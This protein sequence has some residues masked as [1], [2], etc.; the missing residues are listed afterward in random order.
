MK[1]YDDHDD[2]IQRDID[3]RITE[4]ER[5]R[6]AALLADDPGAREE[7]RRLAGLRDL[8]AGLPPEEPPAH[9]SVKILRDI[10]A[11][12]G[13]K[14]A[15][16]FWPGGRLALGY[17]Y[18]AAAGAA[19]AILAIH[20]ATGGRV[21][22]PEPSPRNAVATIGSGATNPAGPWLSYRGLDGSIAVDVAPPAQGTLDVTVA[23]DA[24]AF[25]LLGVTNKSGGLDQL[26]AGDGHVRWAQDRPQRVTLLLAP[27][28]AAGA[29]VEVK[30][31][32]EGKVLGGGSVEL[33]GMN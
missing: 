5:A 3:G 11:R 22:G 16:G 13:A 15:W 17:G 6:L 9:L 32:A 10:R 29:R 31:S 25:A 18:A 28:T 23:Y 20:V 4:E 24:K 33:P 2:L 8:L 12:R 27:R 26:V 30:Y 14:G 7:H 21:F 1:A 19:V